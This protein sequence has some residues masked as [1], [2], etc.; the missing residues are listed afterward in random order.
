VLP[1]RAE[2]WTREVYKR[3]GEINAWQ[4]NREVPLSQRAL[5]DTYLMGRKVLSVANIVY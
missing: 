4:K 2:K 5:S 1:L 3:K